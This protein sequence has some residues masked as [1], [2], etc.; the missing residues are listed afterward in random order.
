MAKQQGYF[1][2]FDNT[3]FFSN[4]MKRESDERAKMAQEAMM[5]DQGVNVTNDMVQ[6]QSDQNDITNESTQEKNSAMNDTPMNFQE[7]NFRFASPTHIEG[8]EV[9]PINK[10]QPMIPMP[11]EEK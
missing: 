6:A 4:A 5:T 11:G 1:E 3:N 10:S 9:K 7:A 2:E 8:N